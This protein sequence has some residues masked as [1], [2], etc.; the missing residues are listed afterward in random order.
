M[1]WTSR[2]RR[3]SSGNLRPAKHAANR[4]VQKPKMKLTARYRSLRASQGQLRNPDNPDRI[5][6]SAAADKIRNYRDAY[7]VNRQV[8]FLP[9]CM[10]TSGRIHGEFLRLLFFLSNKQADDYFAA[11]GYE[12]RKEEFCHRRGVFF[13]RNRCTIGLACAQA[14]ALRGAPTTAR[15]HVSAPRRRPPPHLAADNFRWADLS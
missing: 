14:I 3:M 2:R 11:L 1:W 8:A 15:R 12:A 7:A 4:F 6:E 10:T 5:L 13:Y 9:A